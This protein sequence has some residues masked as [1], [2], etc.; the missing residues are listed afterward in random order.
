MT[1]QFLAG[2]TP[3]KASSRG[4]WSWPAGLVALIV[5]I[6]LRH[7]PLPAEVLRWAG[8]LLLTLTAFWRSSFTV[9]TLICMLIGTEL[10][11]D[12]P[13]AAIGLHLVAEIFL[14]LVR[15]IVAP[16]IFGALTT[17]IAGHGHL[18]RL[19]R[20][21]LRTFIYFEVITTLALVLGAVAIN[22]SRAG[23]GVRLA[24]TT[25]VG[26]SAQIAHADLEHTI[27][28]IFP[29]NIAQAVAQN[30]ILQVVV[31]AMLVGVAL[32]MLP[33][34]KQ[35]PLLN[36]LR[37][38]TGTMFQTTKIIMYLAP[39]AA[40]AAL[41]YTVG[42]MGLGPLV[43]LFKLLLTFYIALIIF[44][45]LVILPALLIARVPLRRF[46]AA[47]TEPA[48]IGFATSA[49]EA[50]LPLAIENMEKFGVPRWIVSFVIPMGYSFNMD[51]TSL[52]LSIAAIFT[53]QVAGIHLSIAQQAIMLFT[54][55]LTSKGVAG[56]PRATLVI[57]LGTAASLHLPTEPVMM[58]LGIDA[59]MDMGRTALNV[60]GNCA[61]A[62]IAA[63][64]E[65]A[66]EP[67]GA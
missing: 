27:L 29:E 61:A 32:A 44:L 17:G 53:A 18:H 62:A 42:S 20:L 30:Q 26:Q 38:L 19:G 65:G 49:S 48:A 59:C 13:R 51:G 45:L 40:G 52:Y 54:L 11:V 47:C 25:E 55:M 43:S 6:L 8:I 5:G 28:N 34:P 46:L 15:T 21:A 24:A 33:E 66:K 3:E 14:R 10:G 39:A 36:V 31:F 2:R 64:W 56:V 50:A 9:W 41:S 7:H 1:T 58:I 12:A 37:S 60:T 67:N 35:A 22:L 4:N 23:E 57:L 16:L 63:R